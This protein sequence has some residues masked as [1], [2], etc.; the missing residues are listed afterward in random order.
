MKRLFA[1]CHTLF[2]ATLFSMLTLPVDASL[3]E[4]C[5]YHTCLSLS[6]QS[7]MLKCWTESKFNYPA[8]VQVDE[9]LWSVKANE[10]K[11]KEF[12]HKDVEENMLLSIDDPKRWAHAKVPTPLDLSDV[13]K[14]IMPICVN[15]NVRFEQVYKCCFQDVDG[16]PLNPCGRTG[17]AGL[18]KLGCWG[19]NHAADIILIRRKDTD[20]VATT[21]GMVDPIEKRDLKNLA[22]TALRELEE[23]ALKKS[24]LIDE[25]K[26]YIDA[27]NIETVFGG[28]VD[29]V[30][31]TDHAFMVTTVYAVCLTEEFAM[32]LPIQKENEEVV[33]HSVQWRT[34]DEILNDKKGVF[35]SHKMFFEK[36]DAYGQS[37]FRIKMRG[38][39]KRFASSSAVYPF[40]R[41]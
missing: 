8:R 26:A 10:Y 21:G 18:G 28:V 3:A 36:A 12:F 19:P 25:L 29:D 13:L 20:E 22:N 27:G 41:R 14:S 2:V 39:A 30:R 33:K 38:D 23:E 9:R 6:G 32:K 4:L 31:N 7:P 1:A 35:A 17:I 40:A 5:Q 11:P 34:L 15:G 37:L 24:P 16:K